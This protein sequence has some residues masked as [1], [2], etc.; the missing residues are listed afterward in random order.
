MAIHGP[1]ST[2]VDSLCGTPSPKPTG[3]RILNGDPGLPPRS[4][5]STGVDEVF[6]D[7]TPG[8]KPDTS[9]RVI[10]PVQPPLF[11]KGV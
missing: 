11:K 9:G 10:D 4:A 6:Y 2:P 8:G 3:Q 1:I 5:H 7:S